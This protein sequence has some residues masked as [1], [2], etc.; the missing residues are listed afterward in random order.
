[1]TN[2]NRKPLIALVALS[3]ALA[4][5]LAFAQEKAEERRL[6]L[7]SLRRHHMNKPAVAEELGI[8]LRCLYLRMDRHKIPKGKTVLAKYLGISG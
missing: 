5:P 4:M 6:I 2:N 3:A 7:E 1:M 8:T